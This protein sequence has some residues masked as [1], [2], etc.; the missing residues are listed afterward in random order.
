VRSAEDHGSRY[1]LVVT[2][3]LS[4]ELAHHQAADQVQ[5]DQGTN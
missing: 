2:H 4:D 5:R 1:V 3:D